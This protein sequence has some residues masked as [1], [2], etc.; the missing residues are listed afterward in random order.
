MNEI[1]IEEICWQIQVACIAIAGPVIAVLLIAS[2]E[3]RKKK[4]MDNAIK[5]LFDGRDGR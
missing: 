2:R 1:P 4:K 3:L 5:D